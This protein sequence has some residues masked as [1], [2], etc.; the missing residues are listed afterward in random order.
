M[1]KIN[2]IYKITNLINGKIYIG[3]HTF[4][5]LDNNYFGSGIAIKKAIALYGK[6]KFSKEIICICETE[7]ELNEKEI[8]YIKEFDTFKNGYNMTLGGEGM[9][10]NVPSAETIKKA[11]ETRKQFYKNNPQM[12]LKLSEKGK[13]KIGDLNP[14]FGKKL[15]KEHIDKM[16]KARVIAITG[17]KNPSAVSVLCVELNKIFTTAKDAAGFCGLQFS[18]TILKCAKGERKTAGGYT[19]QLI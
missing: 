8:F 12:R 10:G 16:T 4:S 15:P 3:K 9:L 1:K 17:D 11:S 18:T 19:W 13:L 5:K 14:F 2:Y 6:D 7:K